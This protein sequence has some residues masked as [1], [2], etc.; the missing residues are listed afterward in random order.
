MRS[1]PASACSRRAFVRSSIALM[2]G[3][4]S[5]YIGASDRAFIAGA[6]R[7]KSISS[8]KPVRSRCESML[9][10]LE[11]S[12]RTSCSLL[13][14]RLNTPDAAALGHGGVLGD[15][16][17][18]AGLPDARA[19]GEDDEVAL[20]EAGRQRVEVGE[21]GPHAAD[22]AAV[23]VEVV[24][25][26]VGVV[27]ERLERAEPDRHPPLADVEQLALGPVDRLLDLGRVLVAD[28]GDLAGGRDEVA[29]D[30]LALDDPGVLDG[31]DGGRGLVRQARQ[32]RAAAD[33]LEL[34]RPLERLG[35]GDDVDRL[36][37][38]EQLEHR[39]VDRA[40]RG[41]IEVLGAEELGDLDDRIAIDE[42]RPEDGLLGLGAL[43]RKSI[44]Q[45]TPKMTE[46]LCQ[47]EC[48]RRGVRPG[49][50]MRRPIRPGRPPNRPPMLADCGG[51]GGQAGSVE[52]ADDPDQLALDP[53]VVVVHRLGTR[54]WPAG[55]GS[56]PAPCRTS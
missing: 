32:V 9:A 47:V 43:G 42:D 54:R 4:S 16:E 21:A 40:V 39:G 46:G 24:E 34:V 35:D 55:G 11:S 20:L 36:A 3:V 17:G 27:E 48:R 1:R 25:P 38:V 30:G 28:P 2:F 26:V 18:E 56:G 37:L 53:D 22:L 31:V 13:I 19:G 8:R 45:G 7:A 41:P 23:G 50:R 51:L 33:G 52:P 14:S 49:Q 15:V 6:R 44:D 12:R 5:M 29:Q 10:T